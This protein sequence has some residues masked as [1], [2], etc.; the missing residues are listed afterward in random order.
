MKDI[1]NTSK[2]VFFSIFV[3]I[4]FFYF[5][6]CFILRLIIRESFFETLGTF[7]YFDN[8]VVKYISLGFPV[9][10]LVISSSYHK[11]IIQPK[12]NN[13]RLYEWENYTKYKI[14]SYIGLCFC[15]L[16]VFPI[17][18]SWLYRDFYNISDLGFYYLQLVGISIISCISMY[19]AHFT[20]NEYLDKY[21][22]SV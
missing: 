17:F 5:I 2:S 1:W 21:G 20:I 16:P 18:V 15:I 19:I 4:E 13:K 14:N 9:S 11:K 22:E 3:S 8:E 6:L 10:L 7:L 12:E